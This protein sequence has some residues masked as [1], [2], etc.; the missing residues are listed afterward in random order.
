MGYEIQSQQSPGQQSPG[1]QPGGHATKSTAPDR[2]TDDRATSDVDLAIRGDRDALARLFERHRQRLRRMVELRL[3]DRLRGRVDPSDVLQEAFIDLAHKLA[4]YDRKGNLPFFLWLRLVTGERLLQVH[5]RHLTAEKR[6]A[7]REVRLLPDG[8]PEATSMALAAM[9]V[10]QWT[11]A[12][13]RMVRLEMQAKLHETLQQ[14]DDV[15]REVIGLRHFE[16]LTNAEVA[17]VLN[18]GKTAASNRYIRAIKRL[19]ER[20]EKIP[21]FSWE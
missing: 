15:D 16:E 10:G 7:R 1:Q 19:K 21:G 20:L 6:D 11:S 13:Q 12:G 18:L 9:L 8:L 2:A 5:R 14:L 4:E 3:D 17:C